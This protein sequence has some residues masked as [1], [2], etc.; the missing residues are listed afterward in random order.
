M[1]TAQATAQAAPL[2]THLTLKGSVALVSDF[3]LYG[4]QSILYQRDIYPSDDFKM[5]KKFNTQVLTTMDEGL[6]DYLE[7]AMR[8][9]QDWLTRGEVR[10][11]VVAIVEKETQETVERW[12]FDVEVTNRGTEEESTGSAGVGKEHDELVFFGVLD[13]LDMRCGPDA[14]E[15]DRIQ[16]PPLC[17]VCRSPAPQKP[18][19]A[20][21]TKKKTDQQVK[22]EIGAIIKQITASCTFLPMLQEPCAFTI[23]AYTDLQTKIPLEWS[24]S[25]ARLIAEGQAEQVKLRSFST[26]VHNVDALVAYRRTE[27][28][29]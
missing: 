20:A 23:L 29:E 16:L 27:D 26:H 7:R 12:Q 22:N 6:R 9:V 18:A 10:R 3:M 2:R 8:Q 17:V 28:E 21:A 25:D 24:E 15:P 11:I 13:V 14:L 5:I 1:S 19:D 4:I